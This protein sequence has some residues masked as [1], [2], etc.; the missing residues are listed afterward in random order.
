MENM[1]DTAFKLFV[2]LMQPEDTLTI[3]N[4]YIQSFFTKKTYLERDDLN[5]FQ[6]IAE[7][8][9]Q[10]KQPKEGKPLLEGATA[11][12]IDPL[13]YKMGIKIKMK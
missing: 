7:Y 10:V 8:L 1:K 2:I 6:K 4:E 12:I 3:T 9:I 13:L 5:L 11:D